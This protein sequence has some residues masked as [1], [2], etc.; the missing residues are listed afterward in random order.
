M[1]PLNREEVNNEGKIL[2]VKAEGKRPFRI[3]MSGWNGDNK[4][5]LKIEIH[6]QIWTALV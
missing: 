4:I 1:G 5:D 6:I 2:I 3:F